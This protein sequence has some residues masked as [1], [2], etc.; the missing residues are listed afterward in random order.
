[1]PSTLANAQAVHT[2]TKTLWSDTYPFISPNKAD[3]TGKSVLITGA[4]RG[5]GK[6]TAISY[7]TAGADKIIIGAR[8]DLTAVEAQIK[9]AAKDAGH[10]APTVLAVNLDISSEASVR[11]A[12]ELVHQ[13]LDGRLDVLV[14]NAGQT[15]EWH[16]I[17]ETT[18]EEWW[19]TFEVNVNGSY[20]CARY[21]IPLL[22]NSELKT[23]I[24]TSSVSAEHVATGC[25]AYATSKFAVC[26]LVEFISTEYQNQGIVAIAIHPGGVQTELAGRMPGEIAKYLT[27]KPELA[28]DTTLWLT[29]EPRP[30]LSG[31]MVHVNWDMEE[32]E[33]KKE[34]ILAGDLFNF[35]MTV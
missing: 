21:F 34:T 17:G 8:S 11:A 27:D 23:L 15:E 33:T 5:I 26:R 3:L 9:Q 29:K 32:L 12:A 6:A 22:L 7:A 35:R 28:A 14:C 31:R 24:M 10:K 16:P 20:L 4:S 30:W 25:S 1:M 19:N 13:E 18:P 2:F